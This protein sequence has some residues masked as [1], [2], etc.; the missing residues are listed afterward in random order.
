VTME[1]ELSNLLSFGYDIEP[2]G[3]DG[4]LLRA[5]PPS[6]IGF[7]PLRL[8]RAALS[9]RERECRSSTVQDAE[10]RIAARIACHAAIKVNYELTL[11][12]MQY[13]VRELWRARQPSVCPHG[14]PTTLRM[15]WEQIERGF[16]R[17]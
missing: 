14:R 11:E 17:I 2:F 1:E 9:E 16:G 10:S 4:Y 7:D 15:G 12:K 5:V 13:L 8:I 6:L 3:G